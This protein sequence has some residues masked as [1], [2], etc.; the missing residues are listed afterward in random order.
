MWWCYICSL[1]SFQMFLCTKFKTKRCIILDPRWSP[2]GRFGIANAKIASDFQVWESAKNV[3][4]SPSM[5]LI[6]L[7][8]WNLRLHYPNLTPWRSYGHIVIDSVIPIP[9][10][11]LFPLRLLEVTQSADTEAFL[12]KDIGIWQC[13]SWSIFR[14]CFFTSFWWLWMKI[15][16]CHVKPQARRFF[17]HMSIGQE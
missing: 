9:S 11:F 10:M 5:V 17:F 15:W 14:K 4:E 16:P 13:D 8:F 1:F 3:K 7:A 12:W 6:S 2:L